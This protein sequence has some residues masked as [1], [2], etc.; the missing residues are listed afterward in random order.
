MIINI[1][2]RFLSQ[3]LCYSNEQF[4]TLYL[5]HKNWEQA[6]SQKKKKK[7]L[8]TSTR[9]KKNKKSYRNARFIL[10]FWKKTESNWK[11]GIYKK[12]PY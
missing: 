4:L 6:E 7:E 10:C 12:S 3:Q 9:W 5:D 8:R 2:D 1:G 11:S